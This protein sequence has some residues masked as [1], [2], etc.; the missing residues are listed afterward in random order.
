MGHR[1]CASGSS[2]FEDSAPRRSESSGDDLVDRFA[3]VD[4]E[5]FPAGHFQFAGVEAELLQ[6]RGMNIRY[7]VAVLD[8]VEAD[9]VGRPMGDAAFDAAAGHP[10]REAIGMMIATIGPLRGGRP[11][12]SFAKMTI[13]ES[14]RPRC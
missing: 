10:D 7:I 12:N 6:D 13:V 8:G 5:T 2:A 3:V 1:Q 9:F 4:F 11:T 14:S